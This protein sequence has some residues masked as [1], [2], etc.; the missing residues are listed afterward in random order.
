MTTRRVAAAGDVAGRSALFLYNLPLH[1]RELAI[2]ET[3]A[4]GE[5]AGE[6]G[7]RGEGAIQETERK[8]RKKRK[9][10]ERERENTPTPHVCAPARVCARTEEVSSW[11]KLVKRTGADERS[12]HR[13]WPAERREESVPATV[14]RHRGGH[15]SV[16]QPRR[17]GTRQRRIVIVMLDA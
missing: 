13:D 10:R 16:E 3:Q 15:S 1:A 5:C 11:R 6:R 8:K 4:L 12:V 7:E 17:P 9:K 2:E 14:A